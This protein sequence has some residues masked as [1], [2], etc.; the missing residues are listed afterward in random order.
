MRDSGVRRSSTFDGGSANRKGCGLSCRA[1]SPYSLGASGEESRDTIGAAMEDLHGTSARHV[2]MTRLALDEELPD[3]LLGLAR[4]EC[5]PIVDV[6]GEDWPFG[7]QG[8]RVSVAAAPTAEPASNAAT[9]SELDGKA[10]S[11]SSAAAS[12]DSAEL[13]GFVERLM[14]ENDLQRRVI[15]AMRE[16]KEVSEDSLR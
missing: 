5:S 10:P 14:F 7:S 8:E 1:R 4:S 6:L 12:G 9:P 16:G 15:R 11:G 13:R 2:G 3:E